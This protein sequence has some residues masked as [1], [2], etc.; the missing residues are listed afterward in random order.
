L[1]NILVQVL[2][3][4]RPENNQEV[5]ADYRRLN[6]A[7]E[8]AYGC[9]TMQ[10][11][12]TP[13]QLDM[14][15]SILSGKEANFWRIDQIN[16]TLNKLPMAFVNF[17]QRRIRELGPYAPAPEPQQPLPTSWQLRTRAHL[18]KVHCILGKACRR[19]HVSE[20]CA[21]FPEGSP[22]GRLDVVHK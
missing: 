13:N 16:V 19:D 15:L 18:W 22:C 11:S 20:A 6:Q 1:E 21:M 3:S 10:D 8:M 5:V 14:M 9:G 2:K 7:L 4:K 12:P 17:V